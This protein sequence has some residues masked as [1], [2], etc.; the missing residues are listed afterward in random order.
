MPSSILAATSARCWRCSPPMRRSGRS[1]AP[2][3]RAARTSIST[4]ARW[5][6]G[7]ARS[8]SARPSIRRCRPG[9]CASGSTSF[10]SQDWAYYL[11]AIV[12][13]T[14]ALWIAWRRRRRISTAEK[15]VVGLAL[16]TLV[17]FYNFH[18]L[19]FNANTVLTPLWALTTWWFLRSFE[20]RRPAMRRSRDWRR[21]PPC[22][23][24]TGR[25]FCC[26]GS[27]SRRWPIRAAA[28]IS[29]RRRRG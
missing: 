27:A 20:T 18:A 4:W 7:R 5:S 19:K 25:S 9:W 14:V 24:N 11:F 28:A 3:P 10:R 6:P 17:P 2:S 26:S 13:A 12:L 21:P 16:L 23:Q 15:R 1:T 8:R 29:A 22:W